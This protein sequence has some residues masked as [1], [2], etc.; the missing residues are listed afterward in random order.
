[1]MTASN[2][3]QE[4]TSKENQ[5]PC[6]ITNTFIQLESLTLTDVRVKG[7]FQIQMGEEGGTGELLPLNLDINSLHL[8]NLP[9]L[10]FIWKG[11]TSFLSLQKLETVKIY[12]CPKLKT[13]FSI[14]VVTSLPMLMNLGIYTCDELEQIFDLGDARQLQTL[15]SSQQ[16]CFPTLYFISVQN[17]NKLKYL[18]YNLSATHFTSLKYLKIV[19]CSE[20]H[21]AFGFEHEADDGGEEQTAKKG[22]KLLLQELRSITLKNL[23]N[24]KE[25][26]HGFKLKGIVEHSIEECLKYSP[27]LYLNPDM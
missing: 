15:Y 4:T 21:K 7:L 24:F 13:I 1:M 16:L 3:P 26:H 10:N 14:S 19:E 8:G 23:P 17:C 20:L 5:I 25:I 12:G 2:L 27:S 11:P 6:F 22:E 18:F 9:E